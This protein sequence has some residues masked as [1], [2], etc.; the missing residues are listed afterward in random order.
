MSPTAPRTIGSMRAS[1]VRTLLVSWQQ[2]LHERIVNADKWPGQMRVPTFGS[3]MACTNCG[4]GE[5]TSGR[6]GRNSRRG[7]GRKSV[8]KRCAIMR[9]SRP[10][11]ENP[12]LRSAPVL[13]QTYEPTL[14]KVPNA[15]AS[16]TAAPVAIERNYHLVF[17]ALSANA[18]HASA[19]FTR[20]PSGGRCC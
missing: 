18:I 19:R 11:E 10:L 4:G 15:V 9:A 14:R 7:S 8:G 16:R 12:W 3:R 6:T 5:P 2:C 13:Q 17:R 1:G 20:R